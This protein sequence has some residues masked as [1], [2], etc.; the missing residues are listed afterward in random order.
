M[1]NS[2]RSRSYELRGRGG[3]REAG[4]YKGKEGW[5]GRMGAA[6]RVLA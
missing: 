1:E 4:I 6:R 3:S 5:E 2:S